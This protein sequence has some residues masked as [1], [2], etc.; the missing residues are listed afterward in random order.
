[1]GSFDVALSPAA[2]ELGGAV[3]RFELRKTFRGD[4]DGVGEG[5]MLSV[6]EPAAG[7]AGYVAV[8]T[9]DGALHGRRGTFSLAQLGT[10]HGGA[11]TL[12]YVVVPGSGTGEL[13]GITGRMQLDIEAD[14]THRFR[15]TY[16]L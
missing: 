9:V 7:A 4:L 6:G 3:A 13:E 10:M 11:Q 1:M 14:G 8:E 2:P 5:I 12:S 16:D 15:L